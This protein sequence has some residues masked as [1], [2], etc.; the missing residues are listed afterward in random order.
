MKVCEIRLTIL[1]EKQ[2][3]VGIFERGEAGYYSVARKVFGTEPTDPEVYQFVLHHM[4][5]LRFSEPVEEEIKTFK[6]VSPKRRQ[7][8]V[9][10]SQSA[11][12]VITKA[13]QALKT[14]LEKNKKTRKKVS[15]E[16]KNKNWSHLSLTAFGFSNFLVY[17]TTD[18]C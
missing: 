10:K 7:R 11:P 12:S 16:E 18:F 5:E 4:N 3:W 8:E 17:K 14:E 15:S 9:R 1:F 13:Q 2:F 6:C